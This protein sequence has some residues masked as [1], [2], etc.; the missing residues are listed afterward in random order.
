[1]TQREMNLR[2]LAVKDKA[3]FAEF[4]YCILMSNTETL[5]EFRVPGR[6]NI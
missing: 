1:M 2:L 6:K 5:K 3:G 4:F